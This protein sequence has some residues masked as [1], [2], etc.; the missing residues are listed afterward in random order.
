MY[1][2]FYIAHP[3]E[4]EYTKRRNVRV[5][6]EDKMCQTSRSKIKTLERIPIKTILENFKILKV[7]KR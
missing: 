5:A 7:K 6:D 1:I 2:E 3:F 4:E